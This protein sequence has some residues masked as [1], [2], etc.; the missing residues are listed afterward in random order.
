M[1][2]SFSKKEE[3]K[4]YRLAKDWKFSP[5]LQEKL[6]HAIRR[7]INNSWTRDVAEIG[8]KIVIVQYSISVITIP[9]L[10]KMPWHERDFDERLIFLV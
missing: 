8:R 1:C 6:L 2:Y 4:R 7:R 9:P 5:S 3:N 10:N